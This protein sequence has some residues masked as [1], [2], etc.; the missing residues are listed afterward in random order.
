VKWSLVGVAGCGE[1]VERVA[2]TNGCA[3]TSVVMEASC[4]GLTW[5]LNELENAQT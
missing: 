5:K 2:A 4:T 3:D 1:T